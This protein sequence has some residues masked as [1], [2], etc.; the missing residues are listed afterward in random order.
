MRNAPKV[1]LVYP[2]IWSDVFPL[3]ILILSAVLKEAG[4]RTRVFSAVHRR[5]V[6]APPGTVVEEGVSDGVFREFQAVI[7]EFEPDVIALSVVEDA[8]P[9]ATRLLDA[10]PDYAG[11]VI[12]GGVFPTFAPARVIDHPRVDA[13]CIGE[14]EHALVA[15]CQSLEQGRA[16]T[17]VPSLWVKDA[18]GNIHK[19][20]P[21]SPVDLN[22][23]P[24]PDYSILD[25]HRFRGPVPLIAHRGCPYPC[26]F[27]N[28]PAQA[29]LTRQSG[30]TAFFRKQSVVV[31]RRDLETL[32]STCADKL[33]ETGLY[34]CSDTLLA[35]SNQE[36]DAFIEMYS[37]FR[38]P[39]VC[40]TTPET[41]TAERMKKLMD[42]GLKLMNVGV[43]H[44]NEAFRRDVLKRRMP[45]REL[46]R[47]FDVA[48]DAGA[49]ISADFIMGFPGETPE[50]AR[51]SIR[52]SREIRAGARN[53]SLFVPYHGT[54]L[55][56][57][58]E[59][60]GFMEPG[61]LAVWSPEQSQL[62][63]PAFPKGEINRLVAA[64]R[65]RSLAYDL[66]V[67]GAS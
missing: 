4:Y 20:P 24:A 29:Q 13:V 2:N 15:L 11:T 42:V 49:F 25:R 50:L 12:A 9:L 65:S 62:T 67:S 21:A 40:H 48:A 46:K 32:T 35:W 45:N 57:R 26:T 58:A 19:N 44:G 43:Q 66:A 23:L 17:R 33:N 55:R 51:D 59:R 3:S 28:S 61:E 22:A 34:F 7:R 52:F 6:N 30:Q 16:I 39:F 31:L 27:C 54:E 10:V 14:G 36:F 5:R 38:I 41:I 60:D 47:R 37:D 1:L 8:F 56:Q 53:C 18:D 64:F 63:M